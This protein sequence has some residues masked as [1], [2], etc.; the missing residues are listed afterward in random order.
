[1]DTFLAPSNIR[2]CAVMGATGDPPLIS[3][4]RT[5]DTG[6]RCRRCSRGRAT[7]GSARSERRLLAVL[8]TTYTSSLPTLEKRQ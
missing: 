8:A 5:V 4:L 6:H 1:M 3:K 7:S 2:H